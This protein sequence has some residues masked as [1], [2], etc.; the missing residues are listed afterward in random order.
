MPDWASVEVEKLIEAVVTVMR[1]AG[2]LVIV[3]VLGGVMSM[4]TR[5]MKK[6]SA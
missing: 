6:T 1:E 5:N 3:G 2:A 4:Q